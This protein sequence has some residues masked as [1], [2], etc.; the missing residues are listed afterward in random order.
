[1]KQDYKNKYNKT[2]IKNKKSGCNLPAP[3]A[4]KKLRGIRT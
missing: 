3:S 1:M 4:M 2:F